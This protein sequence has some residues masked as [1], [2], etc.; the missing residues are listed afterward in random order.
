MMH[1]KASDADVWRLFE[2][3]FPFVILFFS[4]ILTTSV[5]EKNGLACVSERL[6]GVKIGTC[7]ITRAIISIS[8]FDLQASLSYNPLGVFVYLFFLMRAAYSISQDRRILRVSDKLAILIGIAL[9]V[10]TV[11]LNLQFLW[12]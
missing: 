4:F 3:S 11:V 2:L 1:Q 9:V 5:V 6:I 7:G 8:H 10:Y 12:R